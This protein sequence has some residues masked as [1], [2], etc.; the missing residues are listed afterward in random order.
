MVGHAMS[1]NSL[2]FIRLNHFTS[3]VLY[4]DLTAIKVSQ[5]EI[6][7]SERLEE[8]NLFFHQ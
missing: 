8:R 5:D 4:S 1:L 2:D 3:L 6:D 7:T